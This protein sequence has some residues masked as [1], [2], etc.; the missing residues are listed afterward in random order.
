ARSSVEEKASTYPHERVA[1]CV[2]DAPCVTSAAPGVTRWSAC[3]GTPA[4]AD[5]TRAA[6]SPRRDVARD[7]PRTSARPRPGSAQL[8][9]ASLRPAPCSRARIVRGAGPTTSE[10]PPPTPGG[11]TP[12]PTPGGSTPPPTPGG[13]SVQQHGLVGEGAEEVRLVAHVRVGLPGAGGQVVDEPGLPGREHVLAHDGTGEL[14]RLHVGA[15]ILLRRLAEARRRG[16]E[17]EQRIGEGVEAV[18]VEVL[19]RLPAPVMR[20]GITET[21]RLRGAA[22]A[23]PVA[24]ARQRARA[25]EHPDRVV[26]ALDDDL[27]A[28]AAEVVAREVLRDAGAP[29]LQE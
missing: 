13:S 29:A 14:E 27:V 4:R 7:M 8:F 12:P 1:G 18:E 21:G 28:V 25:G 10:S 19:G 22:G 11:S 17:R 6:A 15:P 23:H 5:S 2:T 24:H 9:A 3:A 20:V 16:A 26:Q